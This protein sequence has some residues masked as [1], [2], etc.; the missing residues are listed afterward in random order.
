[1]P[2]GHLHSPR[3]PWPPG[4]GRGRGSASLHKARVTGFVGCG[5]PEESQSS[6]LFRKPRLWL[7]A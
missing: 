1:M 2:R 3:A 7:T 6:L 4:V 5:V